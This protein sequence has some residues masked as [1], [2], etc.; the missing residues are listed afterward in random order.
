MMTLN[1]GILLLVSLLRFH[2]IHISY[3]KAE[4]LD[5]VVHIK[6]S[7]YKD[8]LLK[9]TDSWYKGKAGALT[10][11]ALEQAEANYIKEH[12]RFWSG[13]GFTHQLTATT[14]T[15]SEDGS[16]VIFDATYTSDIPIV[17]LSVDDRVICEDY[18]DQM[19]ILTLKAFGKDHNIISTASKPTTTISNS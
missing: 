19:N 13:K 14:F 4:V 18:S 10:G 2:S 8:D 1:I 6:I 11:S 9:A 12:V 5:R 17:I 7:Y 15:L 3:A 16:S